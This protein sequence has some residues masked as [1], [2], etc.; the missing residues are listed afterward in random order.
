[1]TV[2]SPLVRPRILYLEDDEDIRE[3]LAD[4]LRDAG[5]DVTA[6]GTAEAALSALREQPRFELLLTDFRLPA[7]NADWLLARAVEEGLLESTPVIVLT[8]ERHPPGVVEVFHVLQK[9]VDVGLLLSHIA[10][11]V[12]RKAPIAPPIGEGARIWLRLYVS[13]SMESLNAERHLRALLANTIDEGS[14]QR[15]RDLV[16]LTVFDVTATSPEMFDAIEEDRVI[17]TPTLVRRAPGGRA[18]FLGDCSQRGVVETMLREALALSP[19][20]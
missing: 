12:E 18:S 20:V 4:L 13:S 8:G 7:E 2:S 6:L 9:P 11:C 15:L 16:V 19:G 5:Y 10:R 14:G 1:M 17:V 3:L